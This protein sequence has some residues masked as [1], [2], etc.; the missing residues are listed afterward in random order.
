MLTCRVCE[1][2]GEHAQ[3]V[4]REMLFG[5]REEFRYFECSNC[6]TL[7][8]TSIPHNLAQYYPQTYQDV[9]LKTPVVATG[10]R[11]FLRQQRAAYM[12]GKMNPVGWLISKAGP[13]YF[14]YWHWF[15][16][17][18]VT[19]T[20]KILDVGCGT[21]DL[22]HELRIQGFTR[23]VGQDF[24]QQNHLPGVTVIN[25]PL[26]ELHGEYD[27]IM[28]HHSLEHMPDP[29]EAIKH[30]KR[31]CAPKG[32]ILLRIPIAD[33]LAW[34]EYGVN[35]YAIDA[36]RHLV[37]PSEKGLRLLAQRLQLR[38]CRIEYD[39]NEMQ[40]ICSEQ[41]ASGIPLKDPRSYFIR[42]DTAVFTKEQMRIFRE[43]AKRA[44]EQCEGDQACLYLTH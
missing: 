18:N 23:L 9:S 43:R 2:T 4:V 41:C 10:V 14:P 16:N 32:T 1:T 31:L 22:L 6:G 12:L 33:C 3:Y 38:I 30:L 26:E 34:K 27:L 8:I 20:T 44:N 13:N 11:L 42:R 36:P 29:I 19:C 7:Q 39:S 24:F 28:L 37:I 5:T 25:L 21:G 40:F 17:A 15:R 35:W